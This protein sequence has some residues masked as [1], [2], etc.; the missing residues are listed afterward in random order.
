MAVVGTEIKISGAEFRARR[1]ALKQEII[2]KGCTGA[3][4]FDSYYILYYTGFA[5][6]PTER[7]IA[8]VMNAAGRTAMFV[9]RMETEHV[10][11]TTPVDKIAHYEEYPG[12]PHPMHILAERQTVMVTRGF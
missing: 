10:E 6:I 5:F 8:F 4:L 3:V 11:A 2:A 12:D 7:P 1:E 9:P